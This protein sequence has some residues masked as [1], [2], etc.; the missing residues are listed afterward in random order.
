MMRVMNDYM[1]CLGYTMETKDT[2]Q[3]WSH[4]FVD[5]VEYALFNDKTQVWFDG[6]SKFR[7]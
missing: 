1:I 4:I 7:A 2:R 6:P 3:G 5:G